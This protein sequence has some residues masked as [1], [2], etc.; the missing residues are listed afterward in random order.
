[1]IRTLLQATSALIYWVALAMVLLLGAMPGHADVSIH[2][3]GVSDVG[4]TPTGDVHAPEAE[5]NLGREEPSDA[6]LH[7]GGALVCLET[8]S[9]LSR[10]PVYSAY[11][12]AVFEPPS[13]LVAG[14]D[15][16]PP[17]A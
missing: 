10:V 11:P 16:R 13:D 6:G 14:F 3:Q 15:P 8:L 5:S 4:T 1:M 17:P 12:A 2:A 9:L 7:C